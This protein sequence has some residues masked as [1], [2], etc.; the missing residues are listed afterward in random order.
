MSSKYFIWIVHVPMYLWDFSWKFWDFQSI[1]RALNELSG[2][3]FTRENNF[4]KENPIY[5]FRLGR[6]CGPDPIRSCPASSPT[7]PIGQRRPWPSRPAPLL[8]LGLGVCAQHSRVSRPI[9]VQAEPP[10]APP[11]SRRRHRP[12]VGR[13][14]CTALPTG[15][16]SS[17]TRFV[18]SVDL[19]GK[20]A[21][22]GDTW[23]R[24]RAV[25]LLPDANQ[26]P[27][28]RHGW[29]TEPPPPASPLPPQLQFRW[30]PSISNAGEPPYELLSAS[31]TSCASQ[32]NLQAS[33]APPP[34]E[35]RAV[36]RLSPARLQNPVE[37]GPP[38][39]RWAPPWPAL[40][41]LS[42]FSRSAELLVMPNA[43]VL[44]RQGCRMPLS[45][46]QR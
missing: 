3:F 15:A 18:A 28:R 1:F 8:T 39:P 21:P 46:G 16:A 34:L 41:L 30:A 42:T 36:D 37:P 40:L 20:R 45:I 19:Q 17:L 11:V 27:E 32:V 10:H 5:P 6:A 14:R 38:R 35:A 2:F 9:K 44:A 24:A 23:R 26:P 33:G 22:P 13:L 29:G 43:G 4:W 25:G 31:S 7:R 12:R